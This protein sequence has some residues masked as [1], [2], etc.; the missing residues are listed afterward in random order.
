MKGF[1][2]INSFLLG[3]LL[4]LLG[5]Y[6]D[7]GS[8]NY[9]DINEINIELPATVNVRLS[10]EEAVPVSIEPK[11][12][13][14]LEKEE[15]HLS[16][17][18]EKEVKKSTGLK[19]WVECGQEKTCQ[20]V[21]QPT[22]VES[23]TIRL[24]VT[25]H[26]EDG[27][28]W[29][30]VTTVRPIVPYSRSWF[31]LQY[32]DGKCVLGAVD[33]EGSGGVVIPD[34]YKM[35]MKQDLPIG[36]TPKYLLTDW[37]FGSQ[38]G[39]F[40]NPQQPVIIIGTDQDVH[41]M[42]AVSFNQ[43]YTYQAM[44]HVKVVN[45]DNN[46]SP[47]WLVTNTYQRLGEVLSDNGKLY[48]AN[49]DGFSVYYPL[50]WESTSE[51]SYKITKIAPILEYGFI[52]YDEQNH[53][54]LRCKKYDEMMEGYRDNKMFRKYGYNNYFYPSK[55][56]K[57]IG[58][59]GEN[60]KA[61]NV[62]NPDNIGDDKIMINMNMIRSN[63]LAT[64]FSTSDRKIHVYDFNGEGFNGETAICAG[65]YTF[66]LPGGMSVDEMRVTT[67]YVF[68]KTLFIAGGNKIYKVDFNRTVP[69]MTLLYEYENAAVK[70]TGLKFKNEHYDWGY[71]ADPNDWD[72]EW[73]W[74]G[75]PYRLGVSLDYG[76]NEG[77]ILEL[78]LTTT[79]EVERDSEVLEYK[80][81]GK[82]VDFGYSV[83]L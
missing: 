23:Q 72:S 50:Q 5:C 13:Q 6:D 30:K 39:S 2:K 70:I 55:V 47:D 11:L 28:E 4:L 63:V 66:D 81:F 68:G 12:S 1:V 37:A 45:G 10:K 22:D 44:L 43:I 20:L 52:F 31:V 77:G 15:S 64:F 40:I 73:I 29:Y 14:T 9:H 71:S 24:I 26:R 54:F 82:I 46:F 83:K 18:W 21:F 51:E 36:G 8:Y 17:R 53:R 57:K 56:V 76:G 78:K 58:K 59:I 3:S 27:S 65:K 25:D 74:L 41:L 62:F 7:K 79:G 67:C 35:D 19:E 69:R 80:G 49:D 33:G 61:E 42:N 32:T 48:M 60:P 38:E 16:Y 34:A 75:T